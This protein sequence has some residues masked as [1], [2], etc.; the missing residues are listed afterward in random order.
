[1]ETV[2]FK[3]EMPML[4]FIEFGINVQRFSNDSS[5]MI[6]RNLQPIKRLRVM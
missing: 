1:M 6:M 5:F 2:S 4:I 3:M